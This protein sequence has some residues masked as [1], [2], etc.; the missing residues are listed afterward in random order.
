MSGAK[1]SGKVRHI[2]GTR[3][4][5]GYPYIEVGQAG[6]G[7]HMYPHIHHAS[8]LRALPPARCACI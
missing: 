1:P 4:A 2:V 6:G 3:I 7:S 5:A 8:G